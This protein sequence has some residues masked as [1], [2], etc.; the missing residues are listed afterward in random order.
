[1]ITNR[2]SIRVGYTPERIIEM[3]RLYESTH[4]N[5]RRHLLGILAFESESIVYTN[6]FMLGF[7]TLQ[8]FISKSDDRLVPS[9]TLTIVK[10]ILHGLCNCNQVSHGCISMDSIYV[11]KEQGSSMFVILGPFDHGSTSVNDDLLAVAVL[12]HD[13][14]DPNLFH[15]IS[16]HARAQ[17]GSSIGDLLR[18]PVFDTCEIPAPCPVDL[19]SLSNE[20]TR[21]T[22]VSHPR[23]IQSSSTPAPDQVHDPESLEQSKPLSKNESLFS[24]TLTYI[25][26]RFT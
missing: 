14:G 19:S 16:E 8:S 22:R 9:D 17:D 26:S 20:L 25:W 18:H 7:V 15:I 10:S 24:A 3:R 11:R 23:P 4:E 5:E 1:M 6:P 12:A 2:N 21:F 13:L